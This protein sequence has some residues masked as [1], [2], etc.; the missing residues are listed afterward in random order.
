MK[1]AIIAWFVYLLCRWPALPPTQA[2]SFVQ[3]LAGGDPQRRSYR[4]CC[5]L[6]DTTP[7]EL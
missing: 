6:V 4:F 3:G 1:Q 2:T 7:S 5:W